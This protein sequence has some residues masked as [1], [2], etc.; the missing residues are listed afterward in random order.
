MKLI[1]FFNIKTCYKTLEILQQIVKNRSK[2]DL[3]QNFIFFL[4]KIVLFSFAKKCK[5]LNFKNLNNFC[6]FLRTEIVCEIIQLL[7][8]FQLA[9]TYGIPGRE[10]FSTSRY[11]YC[12][13]D[14]NV[15]GPGL[16]F[17]VIIRV[18]SREYMV[19]WNGKLIFT[20]P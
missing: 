9:F 5:L 18:V 4:L 10:S 17:R 13:E 19:F 6:F 1:S 20:M 11:K 3:K 8:L 14:K 16:P 2:V 15:V 12:N 7:Y